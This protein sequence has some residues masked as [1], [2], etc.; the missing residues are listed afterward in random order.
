MA[1]ANR[2]VSAKSNNRD[3][4]KSTLDVQN[5]LYKELCTL[6]VSTAHDALEALHRQLS[7]V[8]RSSPWHSLYCKDR[9][10]TNPRLAFQSVEEIRLTVAQSRSRQHRFLLPR[11]YVLISDYNLIKIHVK[12]PGTGHCRSS[13]FIKHTL[14]PLRRVLRLWR[15]LE[16]ISTH[17]EQQH[18]VSRINQCCI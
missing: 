2:C 12:P 7:N 4:P 13:N 3:M 5:T 16:I 10:G 11:H 15:D 1:E 14:R 9:G 6:C 8:Y 18:K 17:E